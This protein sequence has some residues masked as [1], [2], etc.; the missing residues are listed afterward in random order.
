[1][2]AQPLEVKTY[3]HTDP[4]FKEVVNF[5][6]NKYFHNGGGEEAEV[7]VNWN[8]R[9]VKEDGVVSFYACNSALSNAI[10]RCRQGISSVE[11]LPEGATLYFYK[12]FVRPM[13]MVLKVPRK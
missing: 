6:E 9:E 1:M 13:H 3:R 2:Q 10:K 5:L 12:E 8:K 11:V 7:I 4:L